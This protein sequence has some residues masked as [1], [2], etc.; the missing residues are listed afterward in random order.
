MQ[1][2]WSAL[3]ALWTILSGPILSGPLMPAS[4][5]PASST[6]SSS[7]KPISME[8]AKSSL[9]QLAIQPTQAAKR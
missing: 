4:R 9:Q 3:I 2:R 1:L 7:G 6:I 8:R 5:V